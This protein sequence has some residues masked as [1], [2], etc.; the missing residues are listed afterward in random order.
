MEIQAEIEAV[1][2]DRLLKAVDQKVKSLEP[3]KIKDA[4]QTVQEMN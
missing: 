2:K 3:T 4:L 1:M